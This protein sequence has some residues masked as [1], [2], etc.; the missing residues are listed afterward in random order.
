MSKSRAAA[1]LGLVFASG[2]LLGQAR[3]TPADIVDPRET[4]PYLC[5]FID[6]AQASLKTNLGPKPKY[7]VRP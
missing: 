3:W 2:A 5:H 4:R 6:A 1:V 7:G